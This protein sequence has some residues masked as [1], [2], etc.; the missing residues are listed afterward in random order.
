VTTSGQG[1]T[2]VATAQRLNQ[3]NHYGTE[4]P[5]NRTFSYLKLCNEILDMP[6]Q[7]VFIQIASASFAKEMASLQISSSSVEG[8]LDAST[9]ATFR[10]H[11]SIKQLVKTG[12]SKLTGGRNR[13][14][15]NQ[16][17]NNYQIII[18]KC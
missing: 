2:A 5:L 9:A 12:V 11:E 18:H 10:C 16:A 7:Q 8:I 14:V 6:P 15:N 4:K 17:N 1:R 3:I 13:L